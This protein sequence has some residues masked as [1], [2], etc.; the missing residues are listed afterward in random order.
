[1]C[2]I[3]GLVT[4]TRSSPD[5]SRAL[6]KALG[7]LLHRGPDSAGLTSWESGSGARVDLGMTRLAVLDL[8]E[9]AQQPMTTSDGRFTLVYNGEITNFRELR[10]ALLAQGRTFR[11]SGDTEVLLGCWETSGVDCLAR[12]EGMYAFAIL[13]RLEQTLTLC[14]DP[15]GI[16]PLYFRSMGSR[17]VA[18]A[19]EVPSLLSMGSDR[20]KLNWAAAAH[21]LASGLCDTSEETFIEGLFAVRPGEVM[22]VCLHSGD[23]SRERPAWFPSIQTQDPLTRNEAALE[24]RSLVLA[25]VERNLRADVPIGIPLSGGLDSSTVAC[26]VRAVAPDYPLRLFTFIPSQVAAQE[27]P[28]A[29][30]VAE[31]L[32][33]DVH[34]VQP[35]SHNFL[36]DSDRLIRA[37]GEPFGS[38]SIYAQFCVFQAMHEQGIVVSLDGQGADE[39]F[40]G[41]HG[42]P[43]QRMRSLLETKQWGASFRYMNHWRRFPDRS[44]AKGLFHTGTALAPRAFGRLGGRFLP[45]FS[46]AGVDHR[47]LR[48]RGGLWAWPS[49][50]IDASGAEGA[51][52]KA[53]LRT[54]L[55]TRGLQALLRHADRN[56]MHF[57]VENRVPFLDKSLVDYTLSLPE[58]WLVGE[59]GSTKVILRDAVRSLVPMQIIERRDKV[60]FEGDEHW[61][62]AHQQSMV[63]RIQE[64]P[65]IGFL[66]KHMIVDALKS[67]PRQGRVSSNQMWRIFNL[68]RWIDLFDVQG[69]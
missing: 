59:D 3:A 33:S 40:G 52:V 23:V 56:S 37:Q 34:V 49:S 51:R 9:A 55:T 5:S 47:A 45:G 44:L 66:N 19:S 6:E 25:S 54:S 22:R 68:Y 4:F 63:R 42:F 29:L 17:G 57:S 11:S 21:F 62:E 69:T 13:D 60:G 7:T 27:L 58:N 14:R 53:E 48:E 35:S 8:S 30:K 1:M 65:D 26:A 31:H 18:F 20:P 16:K 67:S 43:G 39:V 64:A 38:T 61:I 50:Q 15:F 10:G 28:W 41:Y 36:D 46:L 32:N 12:L 2:G 24:V